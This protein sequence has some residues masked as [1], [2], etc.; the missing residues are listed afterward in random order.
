V[1]IKWGD[2]MGNLCSTPLMQFIGKNETGVDT[3]FNYT[4]PIEYKDGQIDV[5]ATEFAI[6]KAC[7]MN[8]CFFTMDLTTRLIYFHIMDGAKATRNGQ[9]P[10]D[11]VPNP[12]PKDE[13]ADY[14]SEEESDEEPAA[15]PTPAPTPQPTTKLSGLPNFQNDVTVSYGASYVG[16]SFTLDQS[17]STMDY[18]RAWQLAVPGLSWSDTSG[19][20]GGKGSL[21]EVQIQPQQFAL[22]NTAYAQ[23]YSCVVCRRYAR[24]P[25]VWYY[26]GWTRQ[27]TSTQICGYITNMG[28]QGQVQF[29]T[30]GYGVT[31]V[32]PGARSGMNGAYT[33]MLT[34]SDVQAEIIAN[35]SLNQSVQGQMGFVYDASVGYYG[36][37]TWLSQI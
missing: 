25:Q 8:G 23:W 24:D 5:D 18:S 36:Q 29:W 32:S 34:S 37:V 30:T 4:V 6:L 20:I 26:S 33:Y 28:T 16:S 9:I 1:Y 19:A 17:T 31:S 27:G 21:A 10:R 7:P 15:E 11:W 22:R 14:D 13:S 12:D 35:M 3:L 2:V